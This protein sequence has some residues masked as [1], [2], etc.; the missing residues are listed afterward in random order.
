M[1]HPSQTTSH[2][3]WMTPTTTTICLTLESVDSVEGP[4]EFPP[5]TPA[6]PE[7]VAGLPR[8]VTLKMALVA[9]DEVDR[10]VVFPQRAAV[11]KSVLNFLRG[12]LW[13]KLLGQV[14]LETLH[15]AATRVVAPTSRRRCDHTVEVGGSVRRFLPEVSGSSQCI[16]Q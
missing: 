1:S 6:E 9:L 13:K 3:Q 11:M 16:V 4:Q 15:A 10:A 14:S 12:P 2:H 8:K 7:L 5:D